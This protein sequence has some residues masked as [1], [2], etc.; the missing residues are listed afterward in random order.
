MGEKEN[1]TQSQ[2]PRI[3]K[4][5]IVTLVFGVGGLCTLGMVEPHHGL[6]AS[7]IY[8]LLVLRASAIGTFV[9]GTIA[10]M[11]MSI[12]GGVVLKGLGFAIV[13]M[14]AAAVSLILGVLGLAPRPARPSPGMV[15]AINLSGLGKAVHIYAGDYDDQYPTA[16]KWCDLL[17]TYLEVS[18]KQLVC[19]L[20]DAKEG[21]SSYAFNKNLIGKKPA[22]VPPDVVLLFETNFGKN[23]LGRQALLADRDWHKFLDYPDSGKKV[24]KLRWNQIGGPEILTTENHEGKGCNVLF[25]DY[26]VEFV[27]TERLGELRWRV[28]E[29]EKQF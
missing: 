16:D 21:E 15:C 14:T 13:G 12:R 28:E 6:T 1:N 20:S 10:I 24:Y 3:S 8:A 22:E 27:K 19:P 9:V 29:N 7:Y 23:P 2:R 25:N 4:L 11:V 17:I 18:P 5:A 26:H